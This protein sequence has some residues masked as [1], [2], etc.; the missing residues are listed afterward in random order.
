MLN[1]RKGLAVVM[2]IAFSISLNAKDK[3]GVIMTVDGE[4]IPSEEFLYL[5][6]KNN[7]QLEQPQSID[8]Y[9]KLFEVYRLK[10]AEAKKESIDTTSAFKAEMNQYKRELLEP[11]ITDTVFFNQLVEEACEREKVLVESSHI[12]FIRSHNE[13]KDKR[14]VEVLDSLRGELLKGADFILL[15]KQYSQDKFS[16]DKGGYLGYAPA[17]TFPYDFETTVY[18]TPEGEISDIVESHVGWHIVKAGGRK[19]VEEFNRQPRSYQ[20]VKEEVIRKS[21][22]PFDSRYEK[23]RNHTLSRL[24]AKYPSMSNALK[25]LPEQEALDILIAEEEINQYASNPEY[26]NLVDEYTNG[27]LL[28]E[29]SVK[30]IWD[31]AGNDEDGLNDFYNKHKDSYV[32]ET[33]HAKGFLIQTVNDSIADVIKSELSKVPQDSVVSHVKTNFKKVAQIDKFNMA[34]GSN[35]MIDHLMFGKEKSTPKNK[36]FKTYFVV[37]ERLVNAPE[38][39]DDVRNSVVSDYQEEL[40]RQWVE[41]LKNQH[42]VEINQKELGR[43]RKKLDTSN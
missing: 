23:I 12:M 32:W 30:N 41:S 14:S 18:E 26:R 28:Y 29:V 3:K 8:E 9:L 40:E 34:E 4:E 24:M 33:P 39:I 42:T 2:S 21:S 1:L 5:Y 7:N 13:E 36:N 20:Q 25:E 6:Q 17:G 10:V 35:P 27:S 16:S 38:G 43:I 19:P 22:S 31:K 11:Y 15:A 37:N